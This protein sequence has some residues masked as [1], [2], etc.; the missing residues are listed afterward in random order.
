MWNYVKGRIRRS[1]TEEHS[2]S[3][4]G[5]GPGP[6]GDDTKVLLGHGKSEAVELTNSRGSCFSYHRTF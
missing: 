2:A 6:N 1:R 5:P 4:T 3:M